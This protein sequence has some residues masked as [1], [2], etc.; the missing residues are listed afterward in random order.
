MKEN[1]VSIF[2]Y[3]GIP[4]LNNGAVNSTYNMVSIT[5]TVGIAQS[6]ICLLVFN[7]NRNLE[8]IKFITSNYIPG[9]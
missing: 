4:K 9:I 1:E 5:I 7:N 8:Q 2:F 6:F 3:R